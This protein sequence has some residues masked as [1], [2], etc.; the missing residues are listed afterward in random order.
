M[1]RSDLRPGDKIRIVGYSG[2]STI[3]DY[4]IELWKKSKGSVGYE[5]DTHYADMS[6]WTPV[7][8]PLPTIPENL[9]IGDLVRCNHSNYRGR[10]TEIKEYGIEFQ[11]DVLT[12]PIITNSWECIAR[13]DSDL[14]SQAN[15]VVKQLVFIPGSRSR[16]KVDEEQQ[17]NTEVLTDGLSIR[18]NKQEMEEIISVISTL[19]LNNTYPDSSRRKDVECLLSRLKSKT[20]S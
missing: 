8:L 15:P 4:D 18:L 11:P 20:L 14:K 9:R 17:S 3:G 5:S 7:Y 1:K 2:D 16:F 10:V 19:A 6:I 13:D 12:K